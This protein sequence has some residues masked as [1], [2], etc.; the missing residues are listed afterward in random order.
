[1]NKKNLEWAL[2]IALLSLSLTSCSFDSILPGSDPT[3][4]AKFDKAI[5]NN[6]EDQET[7]VSDSKIAVNIKNKAKKGSKPKTNEFTNISDRPEID[8]KTDGLSRP[9][10]QNEEVVEDTPAEEEKPVEEKENP[11]SVNIKEAILV[12]E[13]GNY[14]SAYDP[15]SNG[16]PSQYGSQTF[17]EVT[18][19]GNKMIVKGGFEYNNDQE[20]LSNNTYLFELTDDTE[21][22]IVGAEGDSLQDKSSFTPSPALILIVEGG[23]VRQVRSSS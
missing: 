2:A 18:I 12:T 4:D 11:N 6:N 17:Y 8:Q 7:E 13:D 21:F 5:D 20:I 22:V 15:T 23:K 14:Y 10:P 19:D 16:E 9:R 3:P 1:M